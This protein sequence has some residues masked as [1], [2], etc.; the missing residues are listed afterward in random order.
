MERFPS[1][2]LINPVVNKLGKLSF[3]MYL[4]HF[5]VLR[6]FKWIGLYSVIE[7]GDAVSLL[8]F[9]LTVTVTA[10]ISY[11]LHLCIE[12]PGILLGKNLIGWLEQDEQPETQKIS[13]VSSLNTGDS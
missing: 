4:T 11:F 9:G 2:F 8:H 10:F 12:R 7:K 1:S 5:A 6:L 13:E 3:G